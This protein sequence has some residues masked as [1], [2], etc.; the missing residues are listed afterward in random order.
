MRFPTLLAATL[1]TIPACAVDAVDPADVDEVTV[2][3]G[4]ADATAELRVRVDGLT[5]WMDPVARRTPAGWVIDGRASRNLAGVSS[6]VPDDAFAEAA[7]TSARSFTVTFALGHELNTMLSGLPIFVDLDPTTGASATA[8]VWIKPRLTGFAGSSRIYLNTT[9][10]P[11][12]VGGELV[13]R[14]GATTA[15]GYGEL[16]AWGDAGPATVTAQPSRKFRIDWTY[17]ALANAGTVHATARKDAATVEKT[18]TLQVAVARLGLTRLDP[19]VVWERTCEAD[20]QACLDGLSGADAGAC[21]SYR[22]VQACGGIAT[23]AEIVP[24]QLANELRG[25]LI[26][27]YAAHG[28]DVVASGG[29]TLAQAQAAVDAASFEEVTNAEDNPNGHD[30]AT[31]V[32]HRHPDVAFPGSDRV[33]FVVHERATGAPVEIYDFN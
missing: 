32:V 2:D 14:G 10:D 8:A 13:Y 27:W 25:H 30:L 24:E 4:K 26:D 23:E 7:I 15:A 18:A 3:D 16:A 28:A 12:Y 6:W 33:W 19:S 11:V 9:I 31:Y 5:V 21:G 22:E 17:D 29:N 1:M 20:V